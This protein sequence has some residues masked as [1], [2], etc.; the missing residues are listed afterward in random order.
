MTDLYID[1]STALLEFCAMLKGSPWI[2]LDT[3]FIRERTYYPQLCLIQIAN[4]DQ[5]ACIDPL[6][7]SHLEPLLEI[8]FDPNI[9]KVLHSAY[10]DLEIFFHL[11]GS[12]PAPV[13]DTQLAATLLG[14]GE[15]V[16]YATLVKAL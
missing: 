3:E 10:Q 4:D 7:L 5:V 9:T 15:Q 16:G 13:F 12:V 6:A 2:T 8:I 11:Q 1:N 14:Y